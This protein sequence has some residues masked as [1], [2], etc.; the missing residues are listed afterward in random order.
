[1]ARAQILSPPICDR[2]FT[3]LE[4]LV[5][6]AILSI[7]GAVAIPI[8]SV[9]LP[10]YAL[11]SATRQVQSEL[12]RTRSRA[13]AENTK[14]HVVFSPTSYKIQRHKGKSYKDTGEDKPLPEEIFLGNSSVKTLSFDS[15]GTSNGGTVRLC[16]SN[17]AGK[18]IRVQSSTGRTRVCPMPG[19][20]PLSCN[21]EC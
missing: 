21:G 10:T 7:L 9:L 18:N 13:V 5:V 15:R 8:W 4:L 2:G 17:G 11:N 3:L 16:N 1:M 20:P 12:H 14:F 19:E 6:V